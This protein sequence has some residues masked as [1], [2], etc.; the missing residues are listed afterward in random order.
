MLLFRFITAKKN[1]KRERL[2]GK[3]MKKDKVNKILA[4]VTMCINALLIFNALNLFYGYNFTSKLYLF[5]YPN[6]VLLVNSVLG[7]IGV[8][9]SIMLYKKK[10][11]IKLFLV[12]TLAL[13]LVILSNY[14][15]PFY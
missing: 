3:N 12:I 15:R 4:L 7:I 6:W 9:M 11:S 14:F 10:V 8:F 2:I 1:T 13:W 5:M